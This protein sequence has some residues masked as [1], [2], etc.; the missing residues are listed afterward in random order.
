M[1]VRILAAGFRELFFPRCCSVCGTGLSRGEDYICMKCYAEIPRVESKDGVMEEV[2]ELFAGSRVVDSAV[3]FFRYNRHSRYNE[4]IKDIKYRNTPQLAFSLAEDFARELI[5]NDFF[6]GLDMIVPVPLHRSK[7]RKRGYNQSRY[8]ADGLSKISGVAVV[9]ALEAAIPHD[10]QTSR[11]TER[12]RKNVSGVFAAV[13]DVKGRN[14]LLVD[15]VITTGATLLE[16]CDVLERARVES[17]RILSLA[18]SES[19]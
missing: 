16:C 6:D 9:E 19:F 8:I 12:R 4:I 10:S 14:V 7:L 1:D 2:E 17:V 5:R 3:S 13:E 15:D 18:L 11:S